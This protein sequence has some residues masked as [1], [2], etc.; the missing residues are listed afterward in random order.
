MSSKNLPVLPQ[1]WHFNTSWSNISNRYENKFYVFTNKDINA[2]KKIRHTA[3]IHSRKK[4]FEI[5]LEWYNHI[6]G[7]TDV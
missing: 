4:A 7:E 2:K 6:Y 1:G 3:I 5:F